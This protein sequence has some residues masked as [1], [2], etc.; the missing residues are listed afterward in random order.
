M[1]ACFRCI[2]VVSGPLASLGVGGLLLTGEFD[3]VQS[4]WGVLT[5]SG[6]FADLLETFMMP[7]PCV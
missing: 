3:F 1:S 7:C 4:S 2:R 6:M 5:V